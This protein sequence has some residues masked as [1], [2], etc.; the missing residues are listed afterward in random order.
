MERPRIVRNCI[1][2]QKLIVGSLL[3][4]RHAALTQD[5]TANGPAICARFVG[6]AR[7][8]EGLFARREAV[9][10][11]CGAAFRGGVKRPCYGPN[12]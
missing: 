5:V 7:F 6:V 11:N 4:N 2:V 9:R 8:H 12:R 1:P 10:A 3:R